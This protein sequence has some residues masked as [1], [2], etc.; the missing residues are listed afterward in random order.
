M[1]DVGGSHK[2]PV[3]CP[4]HAPA[5]AAYRPR[6]QPGSSSRLNGYGIAVKTWTRNVERRFGCQGHLDFLGS[7]GDY[8]L[9]ASRGSKRERGPSTWPCAGA[10]TLGAR[11]PRAVEFT[12]YQLLIATC[13]ASP[14]SPCGLGSCVQETGDSGGPASA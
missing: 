4:P 1:V 10:K 11:Q 12:T 5:R 14:T 3:R 9:A 2:K 7:S 6:V 13:R 8:Q